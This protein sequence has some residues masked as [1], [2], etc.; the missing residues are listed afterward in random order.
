M[1]ITNTYEKSESSSKKWKP[2]KNLTK[3]EKQEWQ[4]QKK[5]KLSQ[6]K[7]EFVEKIIETAQ[8]E[9]HLPWESPNFLNF[10]KSLIKLEGIETYNK[11]HPTSTKDRNEGI[12]RGSN[13]IKLMMITDANHYTDSRW[14]TYQHIKKIGGHVKKG[15]KGTPI[16]V[17]NP[18]GKKKNEKGEIVYK[19]DKNGNFILD[20]NGKRIPEEIG[21]FTMQTVFNLCQ[22]EGLKLEP[23]PQLSELA[24][25][26]RNEKMDM[27]IANS[28]APVKHDQYSGTERYYSLFNDEIHVP[29]VFM[30]KS[31]PAY[32]A[33][34]AHE[35]GH[36][37]G[38]PQRCNRNMGGRFGSKSYA[39]E[40]LVA[41]LTAV[42]LSRELGVKI[43]PKEMNNHAEYI[44]SWDNKIKVLTEKPEELYA[45]IN[46]AEK[47][48]EYIKAH[49]LKEDTLN[50]KDTETE[51]KI[52]KQ[53]TEKTN[54]A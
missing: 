23:E 17:Y 35:M 10:P 8:K 51:E 16:F 28:E 36:S 33:T 11:N 14:A 50:K 30:F 7:R 6:V 21:I 44:C 4:K 34:V 39:R 19:K 53:N 5:D 31:M 37:T 46:D 38:H 3:E 54:V 20:E 43:P 27:I 41:E 24:L 2:W 48:A 26:D 15:E 49:M 18:N 52:E 45:I 22:A 32:Y 12:Y 40:E 47:A 25:T 29:P 1:P 9:H 13:L 42:F